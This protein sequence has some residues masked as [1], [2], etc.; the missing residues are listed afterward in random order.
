MA[1]PAV[2]GTINILTN[3]ANLK[4]GNVSTSIGNDG[5]TKYSTLYHLAYLIM[6]CCHYAIDSY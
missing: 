5:Y 6:V 4:G 1:I 3:A 2:G